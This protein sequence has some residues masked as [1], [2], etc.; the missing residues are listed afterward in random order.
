MIPSL[1]RAFNER[2]TAEGYAAFLNAVRARCGV[3]IEFRISETPCFFESALVDEL[4]DTGRVLIHQLV[5]NPEYIR[6]SN[7]TIPPE[8]NVPGEGGRPLFIQVDFGLV[9][10]AS[11]RVRPK[12]VE[13]Q[14]FP[15]LY[16][17]QPELA[18]TYRDSWGLPQDL[19]VFCGGRTREA[20]DDLMRGVLLNGHDPEEVVL[21]EID[22]D[23][24]KTR[25]DFAITE[26]RW[27]VRAVDLGAIRREGRGLF[28]ERDGRRVKIARIYNRT[29]LDELQR[30]NLRLPFD[31]R[32]ELDVEWAGHPN[33]YFRISKFSLP[34][35]RHESVPR[36]RFL[37]EIDHLPA[38][39]EDLILKPLYSFAGTGIVFAP[40]DEQLA[41]I[42]ASD[43]DKYLIQE[44]VRFEPVIET[45][46]GP[47]QVEIRVMYVWHDELTAVLPLLRMGR[48]KMMGVDQN[49]NLEW[50]GASGAL[51]R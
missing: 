15:S 50:V 30:K 27:G 7:A 47:T 14:A 45:P 4:A 44:R 37:N 33:W 34:W 18:E 40:T 2:Y 12:L 32:D 25:P 10:D 21:M 28:Y 22:P 23:H 51:M 48:G 49:R 46:H 20:Y 43:R 8:Y 31:Y 42:P 36:A 38:D 1:R 29:I 19:Q 39:R 17:F 5:D 41:A 11:G 3:P 26:R 16:G 35:L 24:Q 6:A 13:L 9:R